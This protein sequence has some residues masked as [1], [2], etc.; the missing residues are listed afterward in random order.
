[1]VKLMDIKYKLETYKAE[2]EN[3]IN[4]YL[5]KC[6]GDFSRLYE[7]MK[8]S[9]CIG[10]KRIRPILMKLAYEAV[11]GKGDIGAFTTAM[12][13]IHTYS[14]IHDDLPAMD[15]DDLRRGQPTNH[16]Q[17]DE[18]TAILA[19]DGL[20][21]YAFEIMLNDALK[22]KDWARVDATH[23]LAHDCGIRG[24]VAGQMLDLESEG[25]TIHLDILDTIHLYKTGALIKASTKMGAV[26]GQATEA[27]IHALEEYGQYIGKVF[28]IIDDVLDETSTTD[29]LG[30]PVHSDIK[31]CKNTYMRYYS[32]EECYSIS[33]ELTKKAIECLNYLSGDISTLREL[34]ENLVYRKS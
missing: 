29:Q 23:I 17:F 22:K 4:K 10:G 32:L 18:A 8:Y 20:L 5:P 31:N 28:Q 16:R 34:A 27:E 6:E 19:G 1:M 11:G 7:A 2:V 25:K 26:L 3:N 13:M 21:S 9:V 30:K 24:M 12:E 15:N 33:D 14:L